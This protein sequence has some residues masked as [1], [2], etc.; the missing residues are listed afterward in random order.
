MSP[1]TETQIENA[2][3]AALKSC[4]SYNYFNS[5]EEKSSFEDGFSEGFKAAVKWMESNRDP[6]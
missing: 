2:S 5:S 3:D 1:L 4:R 6:K